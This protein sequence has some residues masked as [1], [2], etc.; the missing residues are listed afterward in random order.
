MTK[1]VKEGIDRI[2]TPITI[3]ILA[4]I[5]FTFIFM[6]AY[7]VSAS[8]S[9]IVVAKNL[10]SDISAMTSSVS[11]LEASYLS[12]KS[13]INMDSALA[14]GFKESKSDTVF[15]SRNSLASLSFNR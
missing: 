9:N 4:G 3:W 15:I 11:N 12:A 6:Y 7:F 2:E 8:V 10:Q 5:A 13:S 14:L 1:Y